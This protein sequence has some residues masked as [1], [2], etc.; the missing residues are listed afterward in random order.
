MIYRNVRSSKIKG[1]KKMKKI[2]TAIIIC[3]LIMSFTACSKIDI[4]NKSSSQTATDST[5]QTEQTTEEESQTV[6]ENASEQTDSIELYT[7]A[8]TEAETQKPTEEP[9]E[10]QYTAD[11]YVSVGKEKTYKYKDRTDN[12]Y[13]VTLRMPKVNDIGGVVFNEVNNAIQSDCEQDFTEADMSMKG[14]TSLIVSDMDYKYYLNGNV[15]S[16][17]I[18]HKV[19]VGSF[20]TYGIYNVDVKSG[21]ILDNEGVAQAVG[22]TDY[23]ELR[24]RIKSAIKK[25]Y[26][27]RYA[28]KNI[29][30]YDE[31]FATT[32]SDSNIDNS[33]L[34]IGKDGKIMLH[35]IEY[36]QA[37]GGRSAQIIEID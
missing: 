21:A 13:D 27:E 28:G 25:D 1:V 12:E 11:D 30:G 16:I 29:S 8:E 32:M 33:T 17:V 4:P 31:A 20:V 36:V 18:S 23:E 24:E 3:G 37:G 35:C 15:L 6:G 34:F 9:T 14:K 7:E 10:I 22:I 19:S 26:G 5:S 2:F